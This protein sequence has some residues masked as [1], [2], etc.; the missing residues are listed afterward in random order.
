[1]MPKRSTCREQPEQM[2]VCMRLE[3]GMSTLESGVTDIQ[4]LTQDDYDPADP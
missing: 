2:Q 3:T 1:M 4:Y